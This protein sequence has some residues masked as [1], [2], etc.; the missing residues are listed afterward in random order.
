MNTPKF[1]IITI[2][3]ITSLLPLIFYSRIHTAITEVT[4]D[5]K[6]STKVEQWAVV[7]TAFALKPLYML[8]SLILFILLRK[9]V[10]HD[11]MA[12]RWAFFSF[13]AGESFCALNY[14]LYAENSYLMEYFH[15]LGMNFCFGFFTFFILEYFDK[16]IT[17]FTEIDQKCALIKQCTECY[18][19]AAIE[20]KIIRLVR[21]LIPVFVVLCFIPWLSEVK[22]VSYNSTIWGTLYNFKHPAIFQAYETKY[23]PVMAMIFFIVAFTVL[24][25]KSTN[26]SQSGQVRT[27]EMAKI[28]T[29]AGWGFLGFSFFRLILLQIY[30]ENMTWFNVGEE[31]TEFLFIITG[32]Y[33]VWLF[34]KSVKP[35]F[36]GA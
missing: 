1:L 2:M 20:C 8:L 7:I 27:M 23:S 10:M 17:H 21:F 31:V 29:S 36:F 3:V 30:S 19:H 35:V 28:L 12:L 25:I 22:T 18:K 33:F 26:P 16:R 14:V 15:I 24:L 6:E 5:Y 11:F 13:F 4:P 9:Q 34:R 32:V